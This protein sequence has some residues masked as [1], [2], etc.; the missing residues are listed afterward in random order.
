VGLHA[1]CQ[2]NTVISLHVPASHWCMCTP[3]RQRL[4]A[5]LVPHAENII[6]A[7]L[8]LGSGSFPVASISEG[9]I[10]LCTF[11]HL[12]FSA[13]GAVLVG[14]LAHQRRSCQPGHCPPSPSPAHPSVDTEPTQSTYGVHGKHS[15]HKSTGKFTR[16]AG[17]LN[18][19]IC[20]TEAK[21]ASFYCL[22][23]HPKNQSSNPWVG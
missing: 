2:R 5:D 16:I 22:A 7:D 8:K 18:I 13:E 17:Y 19:T 11:P 14:S 1:L 12:K 21:V 10:R 23:H 6:K 3:A 15:P 20:R 4:G 9:M